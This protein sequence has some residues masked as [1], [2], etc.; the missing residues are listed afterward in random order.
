M[1]NN[2]NLGVIEGNVEDLSE[3][4]PGW[5]TKEE[6]SELKEDCIAEE[7]A[8]EKETSGEEKKDK[9]PRKST[10][11]GVAEDFADLSRLFKKFENIDCST[12]NISLTC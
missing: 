12:E 1:A 10:V 3:V 11:T 6:L 2:L 9:P 4:V 7:E 5:L 8:K